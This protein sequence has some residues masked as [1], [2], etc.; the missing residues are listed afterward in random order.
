[1]LRDLGGAFGKFSWFLLAIEP[2]DETFL[3]YL[4]HNAVVNDI[5]DAGFAARACSSWMRIPSRVA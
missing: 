1:V 3:F 5:I 4:A 2:V